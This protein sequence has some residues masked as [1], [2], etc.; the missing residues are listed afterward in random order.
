M[1]APICLSILSGLSCGL[2]GTQS[3]L[4]KTLGPPPGILYPSMSMSYGQGIFPTL[5][6]SSWGST[7]GYNFDPITGQSLRPSISSPYSF[8]SQS[9][10]T[11]L[12]TSFG[13]SLVDLPD[14]LDID[15]EGPSPSS[16]P[17][18]PHSYRQDGTH[19]NHLLLCGGDNSV[20][21][22]QV[23]PQGKHLFCQYSRQRCVE[24]DPT[25]SP[26]SANKVLVQAGV[27]QGSII[28]RKL[29]KLGPP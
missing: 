19:Y 3:P 23:E 24:G 18:I 17:F 16:C 5:S 6:Y 2:G 29:A 4:V 9:P 10:E 22:T 8:L 15:D 1:L 11:L 20:S 14:L 28:A 25:T 21:L 26:S 7:M 27:V 12:S 13:L